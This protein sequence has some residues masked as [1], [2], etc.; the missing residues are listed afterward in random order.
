M[1]INS[2]TGAKEIGKAGKVVSNH[3]VSFP[4]AEER[5]ARTKLKNDFAVLFSEVRGGNVADFISVIDIGRQFG[6]KSLKM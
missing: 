5:E 1:N 6:Q 4:S 3:V 2:F